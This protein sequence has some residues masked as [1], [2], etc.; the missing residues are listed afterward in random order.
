MKDKK[1]IPE[2]H[3][4]TAYLEILFPSASVVTVEYSDES[5]DS[6]SVMTIRILLASDRAPAEA[7]NISVL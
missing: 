2:R 4:P 1:S 3:T 5:E 6:P 7:L